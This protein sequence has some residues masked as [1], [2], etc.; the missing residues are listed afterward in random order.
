MN[1]N[2]FTD[3]WIF[4]MLNSINTQLDKDTRLRLMELCGRSCAQS[5]VIKTALENKGD[6]DK[7]IIQMGKWLGKENVLRDGQTI[8]LVYQK[9][10]CKIKT[11]IPEGLADTYCDCSRGWLKEM[12]ETIVGKPVEVE[13]KSTIKGG[14]DTCQFV[15]NV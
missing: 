12:F 14:G 6:L 8:Q 5:G 1:K 9:C 10:F 15:V 3:R 2:T 4:S 11:K 7:F 13:I